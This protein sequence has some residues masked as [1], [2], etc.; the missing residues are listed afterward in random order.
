MGRWSRSLGRVVW[1]H[2]DAG[3]N[4]ACPIRGYRLYSKPGVS[5]TSEVDASSAN[6]ISRW[7]SSCMAV[8]GTVGEGA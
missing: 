2:Q 5:K 3:A 4:P 6:P 1:N 8:C 7:C